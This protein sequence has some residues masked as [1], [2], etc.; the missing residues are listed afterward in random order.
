MGSKK[1]SQTWA[2]MLMQ[3]SRM[4]AVARTM[5]HMSKNSLS[6]ALVDK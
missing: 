1:A 2:Q 6:T 4:A 3:R 5:Q